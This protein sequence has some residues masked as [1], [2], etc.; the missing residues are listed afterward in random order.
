MITIISKRQLSHSDLVISNKNISSVYD[1]E[2]QKICGK[3][4]ADFEQAK[5]SLVHFDHIQG[6]SEIDREQI[7]SNLLKLAIYLG[8]DLVKIDFHRQNA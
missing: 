3:L 6:E 2:L 7:F 4:S 1:F 5:T 8:L